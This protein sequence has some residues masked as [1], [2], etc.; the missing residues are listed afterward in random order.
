MH[1][2]GDVDSADA[3]LSQQRYLITE[4]QLRLEKEL[5]TPAR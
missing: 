2:V 3:P 5:Q 1:L 4:L